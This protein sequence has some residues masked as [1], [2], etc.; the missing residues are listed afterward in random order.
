MWMA[1]DDARSPA[2]R[3]H[4]SN[5]WLGKNNKGT[6]KEYQVQLT[7]KHIW[8]RYLYNFDYATNK[9]QIIINNLLFG[10][11]TNWNSSFTDVL[12]TTR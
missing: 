2:I 10:K 9:F 1:T 7:Y 12:D 3:T 8:N 5:N 4:N 11:K 6:S